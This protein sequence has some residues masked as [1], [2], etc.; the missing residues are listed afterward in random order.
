MRPR[1][2]HPSLDCRHVC[3]SC[4]DIG[5]HNSAC[6]WVGVPLTSL[7]SSRVIG[8]IPYLRNPAKR[9]T[10]AS[11]VSLVH[12]DVLLSQ[13]HLRTTDA[14]PEYDVTINPSRRRT[15]GP[16]LS[17]TNARKPPRSGALHHLDRDLIDAFKTNNCHDTGTRHTITG[18]ST[19]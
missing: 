4:F 15:R 10:R 2:R 6:A 16:S 19:H 18:F 8:D 14:G 9:E 1:G 11:R 5:T 7:N 3:W 13:E 17:R 12:L